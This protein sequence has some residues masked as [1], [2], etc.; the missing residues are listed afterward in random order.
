MEQLLL[1]VLGELA[2]DQETWII[3]Y[4]PAAIF[5]GKVPA[6]DVNFINPK[7]T[8]DKEYLVETLPEYKEL[9]NFTNVL[10]EKDIETLDEL[11]KSILEILGRPT[12]DTSKIKITFTVN[13][14]SDDECQML[15]NYE[16]NYIAIDS[17]S[18]LLCT[19]LWMLMTNNAEAEEGTIDNLSVTYTYDEVN[20]FYEKN[21]T[22]KTVIDGIIQAENWT[23][24]SYLGEQIN[25]ILLE[26]TYQV[27]ENNSNEMESL[28]NH[29]IEIRNNNKYEEAYEKSGDDILTESVYYRIL[30]G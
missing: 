21:E 30:E 9:E 29:L 10:E 23:W 8:P 14:H 7:Y 4:G 3:R 1:R 15:I 2:N 5:S 28:K 19:L 12:D 18:D 16:T 6:L 27:D 24:T 13:D 11:I 22:W 20:E 26:E 17:D 25:E